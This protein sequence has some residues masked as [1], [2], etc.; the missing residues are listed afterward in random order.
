VQALLRK[1]PRKRLGK[2]EPA[3]SDT[4]HQRLDLIAAMLATDA[5]L[6]KMLAVIPQHVIT[7]LAEA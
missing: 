6:A 7:I 1:N 4:S 3:L 2:E 5:P